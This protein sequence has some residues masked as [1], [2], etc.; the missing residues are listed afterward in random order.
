MEWVHVIYTFTMDA[1]TAL[2]LVNINITTWAFKPRKALA[3]RSR[4]VHSTYTK[5]AITAI[6]RFYWRVNLTTFAGVMFTTNALVAIYTV[7]T[8]PKYTRGAG[9]FVDVI[10]TVK[11]N[12]SVNAVTN[13]TRIVGATR[14]AILTRVAKT[15]ANELVTEASYNSIWTMTFKRIVHGQTH[16]SKQTRLT[17]TCIQTRFTMFSGKVFS[18]HAH[19]HSVRIFNTGSTILTLWQSMIVSVTLIQNIKQFVCSFMY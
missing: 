16:A 5:L 7:N 13:V 6:T 17:A 9:A 4:C 15:V 8:F 18:T 12:E 14:S 10:L 3:K 11:S 1:R 19:V 2:T